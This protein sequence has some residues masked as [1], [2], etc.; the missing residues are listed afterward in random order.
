MPYG[1]N[2]EGQLVIGD[3]NFKDWMPPIVD[4]KRLSM[5]LVPRDYDQFPQGYYASAPAWSLDDM[6]LIPWE[7]MPERIQDS[8]FQ[9]SRISDIYARGNKGQRIP[10]LNQGSFGY[11]WSYSTTACIQMIRAIANQPYEPLSGHSM[12]AVIKNFRDE[13]AWGCLSL[14][15]ARER[16]V[17]PQRLWPEGNN[18]GSMN[19]AND[20]EA[21]WKEAAKYK[22]T[23][24]WLD[25]KPAV[26]D[27]DMSAQ[28]V[29]TALLSRMPVIADFNHWGHSVA[30][31]DL[32]DVYP[33]RSAR[34]PM[35]Y[36][37][38]LMNSWGD[39]WGTLGAG[40]LKDSKAWP[41][42]GACPR[43]VVGA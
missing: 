22:V 13:G 7:E 24:G 27:R 3:D 5:G 17:Q 26:Y 19:R 2:L 18:P 6:P 38:R 33:N 25:L 23:E 31:M 32:V 40:I 15:F 8:E 43:V 28:Q 41:N 30:L 34:D 36:G 11:C 14:D 42:G 21:N 37:V 35:R 29:A 16:G 20:T 10:A 39:R 1:S 4:G 12:A 9:K